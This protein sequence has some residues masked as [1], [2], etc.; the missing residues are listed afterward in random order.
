MLCAFLLHKTIRN[1][2]YSRYVFVACR[3]IFRYNF[4][5]QRSQET[6]DIIYSYTQVQE[7]QTLL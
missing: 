1:L 4:A 6:D 3:E 2:P 5:M 7:K